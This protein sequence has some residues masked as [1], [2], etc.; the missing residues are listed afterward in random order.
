[1]ELI[2]I[3]EYAGLVDNWYVNTYKTE[4]DPYSAPENYS[5]KFEMHMGFTFEGSTED[6]NY[7]QLYVIDNKKFL[8]NQIK[9]GFSTFSKENY[10]EE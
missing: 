10:C 2:D 8:L 5:E 7:I 4:F 1:M 6:N 9:Y 3:Y